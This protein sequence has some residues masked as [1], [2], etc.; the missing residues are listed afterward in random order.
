MRVTEVNIKKETDYNSNTQ[1][2]NGNNTHIRI[3]RVWDEIQSKCRKL[4]HKKQKPMEIEGDGQK[5]TSNN[6]CAIESNQLMRNQLQQTKSV[7]KDANQRNRSTREGSQAEQEAINHN[8]QNTNA[9]NVVWD[10]NRN[11]ELGKKKKHWP[12][13]G[14][15]GKQRE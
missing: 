10:K 15:H 1:K 2:H 13:M 4:A 5:N 12:T 8:K 7:R 11:R 9:E 3:V 14:N 6:Q